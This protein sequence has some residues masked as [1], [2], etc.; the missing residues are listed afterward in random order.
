M[1]HAQLGLGVEHAEPR[2]DAGAVADVDP[3]QVDRAQSVQP[4]G[5]LGEP[6]L[7]QQ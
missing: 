1:K 6:A 2:I 4:S 5:E 7:D 3:G